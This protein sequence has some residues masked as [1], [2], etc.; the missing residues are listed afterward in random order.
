M[1]NTE[2]LKQLRSLSYELTRAGNARP[3]DPD[4][5]NDVIDRLNGL[6]TSKG[7]RRYQINW[8]M[9]IVTVFWLLALAIVV[10]SILF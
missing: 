3:Y 9:I 4:A 8:I 10:F 7:K 6:F 1:N 2:Y 5:Y